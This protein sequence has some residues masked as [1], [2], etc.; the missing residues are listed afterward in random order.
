M[1]KLSWEIN[2][3]YNIKFSA[4]VGIKVFTVF[5]RGINANKNVIA[6]FELELNN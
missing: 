4:K 3:S 6:W 2:R 1:P 5:S